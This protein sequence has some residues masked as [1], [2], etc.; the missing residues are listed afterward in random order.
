MHLLGKGRRY[1]RLDALVP[2]LRR[3]TDRPRPYPPN[4]KG[5]HGIWRPND[6]FFRFLARR[7]EDPIAFTVTTQDPVRSTIGGDMRG[8][9]NA[10]LTA[11]PI[12]TFFSLLSSLRSP[13]FPHGSSY[14]NLPCFAAGSSAAINRRGPIERIFTVTRKREI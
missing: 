1:P 4:F 11:L 2:Y 14:F 8:W 7:T 12:E 9:K 5:V 13:R 10:I 6:R 3:S